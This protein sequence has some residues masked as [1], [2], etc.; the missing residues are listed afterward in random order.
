MTVG[1]LE[2]Q[3]EFE[4]RKLWKEVAEGIRS[5][6]FDKAATAKTAIEVAQREAR[7]R[8]KQEGT[9]WQLKLF[10]HVESDAAY[11][12]LG[13]MFKASPPTEEGWLFKGPP[14]KQ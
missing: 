8:E 13:A 7:A 4:S 5:G 14:A 11:A 6:D 12:R 3:D 1:P 10:E 2:S 9:S